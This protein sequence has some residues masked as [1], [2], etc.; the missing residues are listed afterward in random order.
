MEDII[1]TK[2]LNMF[3]VLLLAYLTIT[4]FRKVALILN[5]DLGAISFYLGGIFQ[6]LFGLVFIFVNIDT[7][8]FKLVKE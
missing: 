5:P 1:Q 4:V 8:S 6:M 3:L 2:T 7:K